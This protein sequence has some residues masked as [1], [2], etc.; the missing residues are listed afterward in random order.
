VADYRLPDGCFPEHSNSIGCENHKHRYVFAKD[1]GICAD[2]IKYHTHDSLLHD[3]CFRCREL[4]F[5]SINK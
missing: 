1:C 2:M 4:W 5:K 3:K